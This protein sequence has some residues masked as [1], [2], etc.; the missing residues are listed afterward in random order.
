MDMLEVNYL[1]ELGR[2]VV[3][4]TL[5]LASVGK[6]LT[7]ADFRQ[8]LIE[9]FNVPAK[10]AGLSASLIVGVELLLAMVVLFHHGLTWWGM[11]VSGVLFI[12]FSVL[13]AA[14]LLKDN[15]VRCNC[16]GNTEQRISVFDL[17]RNAL[18]VMASI[19]YL[20][21]APLNATLPFNHQLLLLGCAFILIQII[22]HLPDIKIL[23]MQPFLK[24]L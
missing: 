8:N 2:L 19:Y 13:I 15:I 20:F 9:S 18:L 5:F 14:M 6:A 11:L 4:C 24:E 17:F 1:A 12:L 23:I 22:I 16:F 10:L 21:Q 7:F 3:F